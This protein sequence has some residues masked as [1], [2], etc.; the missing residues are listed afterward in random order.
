MN[1]PS[2]VVIGA[3]VMGLGLTWSL[4]KEGAEVTVVGSTNA[5][6]EIGWASVAWSNASSK[7]RRQYPAHYT[8]LN[9]RGVDAAVELAEE[10]GGGWL[11]PTG[12]VQIVSGDEAGAKLAEDVNRLN[13][14]FSYPA[15]LLTAKRFADI[16]P[17]VV[18][19]TGESAAFFARDASI[20]ALGL[21]SALAAAISGSGG[22]LLH[23]RVT[24]IDRAG[25]A[26]GTVHLDSGASLHADVVVFAAGAW[27][28][29]VAALAG[30]DVP[31][32][33]RDDRRV[34][35]LLAAI[36]CPESARGPMIL[37]P[38]VLVRSHLPGQALVGSDRD[39]VPF[40]YASTRAELFVAAETL[41][42]R[43]TDRIP[44]LRPAVVLDVRL[45]MRA[46]SKDGLTIAGAP[47]RVSNAYVLTTHSGFTLSPILGRLAA[48]EICRSVT[49]AELEPYRPVRFE[50]AAT[51]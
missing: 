34:A 43:A 9:S 19:R 28:A 31:M 6:E 49:E 2:V 13:A 20:D 36:T 44:A 25:D 8:A 38:D 47:S 41:L 10:I 40:S 37:T 11:H 26:I 46:I 17:N 42:E 27:T 23:D 29:D 4:L 35:G 16:A 21:L 14:E 5:D 1:N 30:I 3:G 39:G 51:A 18:L 15:E 7:V 50:S 48:A 33:H 45:G 24:A 22:R 12:T 32:L